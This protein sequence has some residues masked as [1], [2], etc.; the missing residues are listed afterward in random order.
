MEQVKVKCILLTILLKY[1]KRFCKE[2]LIPPE[3]IAQDTR[4]FLNESD[5]TKEWFDMNLVR[6]SACNLCKKDLLTYYN[7]ENNTFKNMKWFNA[8]LKSYGYEI[9]ASFTCYRL[10]K[11]QEEAWVLATKRKGTCVRGVKLKDVEIK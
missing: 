5:D 6:D 1:Y 4:R 3:S 2:G 11:N 7:D 8:K 9:G 10:V